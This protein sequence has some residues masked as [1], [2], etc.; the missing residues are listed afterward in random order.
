MPR[1]SI[2][3]NLRL[4]PE[5]QPRPSN[6]HPSALALTLC[7]HSLRTEHGP[8]NYQQTLP[9][10]REPVASIWDVNHWVSLR[11]QKRFGELFG[12]EN[13]SKLVPSAT[14]GFE[15]ETHPGPSI[16]RDVEG[17]VSFRGD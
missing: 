16:L 8:P 9:Y 6:L 3:T 13:T 15:P 10:S 12:E 17:D 1:C 7:D 2:I 11:R 5:Q 14:Q 4:T